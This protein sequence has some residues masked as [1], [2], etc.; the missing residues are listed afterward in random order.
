MENLIVTNLVYTLNIPQG[1]DMRN[2]LLMLH[3]LTY[4]INTLVAIEFKL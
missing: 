4:I 3:K 1:L 2:N